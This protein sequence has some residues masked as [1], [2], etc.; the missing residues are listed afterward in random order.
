MPARR[1]RPIWLLAAC[2]APVHAAV[3][4]VGSVAQLQTALTTAGGNG[5]N[6]F[7]AVRSGHYALTDALGFSGT[8]HKNLYLVGGY[9]AGC[10]SPTAGAL[11]TID[12][13]G[14]TGLIHATLTGPADASAV[15]SLVNLTWENGTE[16]SFFPTYVPA[17]TLQVTDGTL[18]VLRNVFRG[19][20]GAHS[21]YAIL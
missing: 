13:Q 16:I 21:P 5:E 6:D 20:G 15:L 3:F 4:C 1:T 9:D 12:G 17:V 8:D 14:T 7:I 18:Q 11:T 10:T 2:A 19:N